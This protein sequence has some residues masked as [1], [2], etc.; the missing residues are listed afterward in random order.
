MHGLFV[1]LKIIIT[2]FAC[3]LL[4]MTTKPKDIILT[5]NKFGVPFKMTF[6]AMTAIRFIPILLEEWA[7]IINAQQARGARFRKSGIRNLMKVFSRSFST[8]IINSVRRAKVLALA[9]E[10]RAFGA[11]KRRTSLTELQMA[12]TDIIVTAAICSVTGSIVAL[13]ALFPNLF[14]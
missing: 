1:T 13:A 11:S 6:T 2:I 9:M 14:V 3:S 4:L 8:M 5:F 12:R 7:L 10:T